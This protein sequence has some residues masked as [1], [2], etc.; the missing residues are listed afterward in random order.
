ML[1]EIALT[2]GIT[3]EEVRKE[4]EASIDGAYYSGNPLISSITKDGTMPL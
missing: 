4:I 2:E 3:N 1:K